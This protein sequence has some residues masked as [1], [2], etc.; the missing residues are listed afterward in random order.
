MMSDVRK[1]VLLATITVGIVLFIMFRRIS[2]VFLP[3]LVVFFSLLSTLGLMAFL[4]VP[5]KVPTQIL[6]S[7][8]LAVGVGTSVHILAIFFHR[9]RDSADKEDA[10]VYAMEHSGLAVVMTNVTTAA[11]L[12][13]FSTAELA[14]IVDLGVFAGIGV[15]LAFLYTLI[16]LPALL[17]L[18]PIPHK[19]ATVGG[20]NRTVMGRFLTSVGNFSTGH[21]V[22]ILGASIVVMLLS[23]VSIFTIRFS[24]HPLQWFPKDNPIRVATEKIDRELK[25][26][27]SLEVIIDTGKENGLYDPALLNR[28]ETATVHVEKLEYEKLYVGKAWSLTTILKE[29]HQAL[30]ENRPEYYRIPDDR[31]LVAQEFLFFENSGSDDLEDFVDS[32]F[33][34]AR[35]MVKVPFEDAYHA[36]IFITQVNGYFNRYFKEAEV[37]LTGMIG[38]L[39]RTIS[40]AIHSMA[41]SYAIALVVITIL[42]ILLIGGVRLIEHDSE[43][44]SHSVDARCD[45]RAESP[46]GSVYHDGRQHRHRSGGGRHHPFY[47]QLPALLRSERR[48]G[49]GRPPNP[50]DH[51]KGDAGHDNRIIYRI[52]CVFLYHHEQC[53][54]FRNAYRIYDYHGAAVRLF[55]GTGADG[56]CQQEKR[57][58]CGIRIGNQGATINRFQRQ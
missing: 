34:K 48:S 18:V 20:D 17:A 39:A 54:Q 50:P 21:P 44:C 42:M 38:L 45:R 23:V 25:G 10:V 6:P 26:S 15:M 29:I 3:L 55:A 43:P 28:L 22:A 5:I 33:S 14:P 30:N 41:K 19:T 52:L 46:D 49:Q 2:G 12:V 47:A 56:A 13:S 9:Y 7:F 27:I 37:M 36:G 57:S 35:F 11:G 58:H 1:F 8:L 24:H 51:R 53:A 32:Q 40:A 4:G 31:N 16:L